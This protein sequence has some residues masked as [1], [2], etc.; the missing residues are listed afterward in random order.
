[1]F[2]PFNRNISKIAVV[3]FL[4]ESAT[5]CSCEVKEQKIDKLEEVLSLIEKDAFVN[6]LQN[7]SIYVHQERR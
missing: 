7:D 6:I 1:M 3:A 4:N 2:V 5:T